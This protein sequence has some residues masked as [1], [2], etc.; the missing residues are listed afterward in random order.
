MARHEPGKTWM[1]RQAGQYPNGWVETQNDKEILIAYADDK[2]DLE[3][4]ICSRRDARLFAKRIM[5][6]LE[7]TKG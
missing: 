2:L 5:E 4:F 7:G 1:L 3:S 6:C